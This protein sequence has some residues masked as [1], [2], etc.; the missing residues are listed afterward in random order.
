MCYAPE[1]VTA[2]LV[3]GVWQEESETGQFVQDTLQL[4]G[5]SLRQLDDAQRTVMEALLGSCLE[6]PSA[7]AR[8]VAVQYAAV[9]FPE[10]HAVSRLQLLLAT[11]DR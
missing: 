8:Q 4:L 1:F 11:A 2:C 3:S 7:R 6:R 10:S 9:V 5:P